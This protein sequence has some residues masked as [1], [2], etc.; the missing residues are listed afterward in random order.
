MLRKFAPLGFHVCRH[1]E[2]SAQVS[3][4]YRSAHSVLPTPS[5]AFLVSRCRLLEGH[6]IFLADLLPVFVALDY[7]VYVQSMQKD[8][9]T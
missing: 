6:S 3:V 9:E 8:Q 2:L 1:L 5:S 7:N 4:H